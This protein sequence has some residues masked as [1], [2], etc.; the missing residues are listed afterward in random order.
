[1]P[2]RLLIGLACLL[3]VLLGGSFV[4]WRWAE[5][6]VEQGFAAWTQAMAA[7]GWTVHAGA[8]S[9]GGWPLARRLFG[10]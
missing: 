6:R 2:R 8:A 4:A 3:A 5:G 9:R 1:M 10:R 7:D